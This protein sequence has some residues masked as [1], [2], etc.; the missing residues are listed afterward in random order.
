MVFTWTRR[1]INGI[2]AKALAS[3]YEQTKE[4]V[5]TMIIYLLFTEPR[6]VLA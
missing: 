4:V 6:L 1:L 5:W 2:Q 3:G